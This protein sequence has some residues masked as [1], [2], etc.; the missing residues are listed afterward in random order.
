MSTPAD[1]SAPPTSPATAAPAGS[2]T[3]HGDLIP[4]VPA[5]HYRLTAEHTAEHTALGGR[6]PLP[7]AEQFFEVRAPRFALD[8]SFVH[9]Q[10]PPPGT[11]GAFHTTLA[12]LSLTR[13]ALPWERVLPKQDPKQ[14]RAPWLAL[15]LFTENELPGDPQAHGLVETMTVGRFLDQVPPAQSQSERVG[16]EDRDSLC[17]TVRV[18]QALYKAVAPA[19]AELRY[20]AHVRE[21]TVDTPGQ[22]P[23]PPGKDG[24]AVIVTN[25]FPY[26][27]KTQRYVAHLVSQELIGKSSADEVRLLSLHSWSFTSTKD[28]PKAKA[29]SAV[30]GGLAAESRQ[31]PFAA[32]TLPNIS[33]GTGTVGKAVTDRLRTGCYALALHTWTGERSFAFHRGPLAAAKPQPLPRTHGQFLLAA[34]RPDPSRL[35]IYDQTVASFD[36][37]YATAFS[38][39]RL[40]ALCDAD[41]TTAYARALQRRHPRHLRPSHIKAPV[42]RPVHAA[43]PDPADTARVTAWLA[44]L[45]QLRSVPFAYLVPDQ[46]LLPRES[47]RFAYLDA[48][49]LDAATS[50]ALSVA[51]SDKD[52]LMARDKLLTEIKSTLPTPAAAMLIRSELVIRWPALE[53][54]AVHDRTSVPAACHR[55]AP[56][57]L[58]CLFDAVP[59]AVTLAEPHHGWHFGTEDTGKIRLREIS[60]STTGK[61]KDEWVPLALRGPDHYR[62]LHVVGQRGQFNTKLG[63]DI[64]P[65][66]FA[67]QFIAAPRTLTFTKAR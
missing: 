34:G 20:L 63:S 67:L 50:G 19:V 35:L 66:A 18:P 27:A 37:S 29:F 56:D 57:T 54:T 64:S 4:A 30:A 14:D 53:I 17:A 52:A 10:Y 42:T 38:L 3:F 41:F 12:H 36:A 43:T 1:T 8:P 47:V 9:A 39:G 33:D 48:D 26:E 40:L 15:L 6:Q 16:P 49:W 28:A 60:G 5:G 31:P 25:R 44:T 65:A 22:R 59:T 2:L 51:L 21:G 23:G 61:I 13:T 55:P 58:V 46:R 7:K 32:L 24:Y 11:A 62:V 45:R